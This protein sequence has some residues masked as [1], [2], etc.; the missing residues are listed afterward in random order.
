MMKDLVASGLALAL[1][2]TANAQTDSTRIVAWG[3]LLNPQTVMT[4]A[5]AL[6]KSLE[7]P[8]STQWRAKGD[9]RR[10]YRFEAAN[11]TVNYR[12]VIPNGWDGMSKLPLLLFLHSGGANENTN[13]DANSGQLVKLATERGYALVSPLGYQGAYGFHLRLPAVF[14]QQAAANQQIAA[15]TPAAERT[16]QLSEIDVLNVLEIVLNEYPIDRERMYLAGHSMGAGGTW[17]LGAKYPG[18]WAAL[19]PLSG[20]FVL[21]SGYPWE[22]IRPLPVFITEGNNTQSTVASRAAHNYMLV[23]GF[24]VKYKEVVADHEGMI[25]LVLPDVMAFLDT[26]RK[27]PV[28]VAPRFDS[29]SPRGA[30]F[31]A[32]FI[33]GTLRV[34]LPPHD[35]SARA[36][37]SIFNAAGKEMVRG[38]Y[39]TAAG[40]AVVDGMSWPLG[41]YQARIRTQA[42]AGTARFRVME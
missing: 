12:I 4:E 9:Q 25:P 31:S 35:R 19:A 34:A 14:G 13:L 22:N 40:E 16:N 36:E 11:A 32:R 20:P 33:R 5:R 6:A 38:F 29:P 23:N 24:N 7:N 2:A 1:I 15:V 10:S 18:Y 28:A 26:A 3:T 41:A 37:V 42:G 21:E 30:G 27:A 17:Y 39:S 8:A